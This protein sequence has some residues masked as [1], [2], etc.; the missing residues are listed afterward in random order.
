LPWSVPSSPA[1]TNPLRAR[2]G[3]KILTAGVPGRIERR[4]LQLRFG[5]VETARRISGPSHLLK[6]LGQADEIAA[7]T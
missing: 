5:D 2:Q 1:W 4:R 3:R 7:T 6:R